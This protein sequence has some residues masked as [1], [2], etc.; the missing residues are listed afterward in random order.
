VLCFGVFL[1]VWL[2]LGFLVCGGVCLLV[3]GVCVVV[4]VVFCVLWVFL[5]FCVVFV[6]GLGGVGVCFCGGWL[7]CFVVVC[8]FV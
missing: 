7:D 8:V 1:L 4:C 5:L 3:W 6:C 2:L